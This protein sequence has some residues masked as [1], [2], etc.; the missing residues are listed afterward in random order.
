MLEDDAVTEEKKEVEHLNKN[1]ME[2]KKMTLQEAQEFVKNTKYIVW[3]EDESRQLQMKLFEFG[4][5]W[6]CG[7]PIVSHTEHPYLFVDE[8]LN[9]TY[10]HRDEYRL[11]E[12]SCKRFLLKDDVLN[13]KTKE[14]QKP[15]FD[16]NTLQ[17]FDRVLVREDGEI[18]LARFFDC[19]D[20]A[21]NVTSGHSWSYCI[22]YNDDTKHLHGTCDEEP[23]FYKL[24]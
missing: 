2:T 18:W 11:F 5:G 9:I 21:Y 20:G 16:P 13:V 7:G 17:P 3:S 15:K 6:F 19:Y 22:P 24:D 14:Q 4:C 12:D 8:K 10:K 1:I 23:E